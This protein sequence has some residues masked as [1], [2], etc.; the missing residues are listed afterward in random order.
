VSS[1]ALF[2]QRHARE[3]ALAAVC[4]ILFLTFLDNT[5]VS[6]AL[7][8][9][10]SS[11]S[12]SVSGLQWIVD[13]YMLAFAALMLT[14]GTLGDL[15]GRKRVMLG[16]VALF[17][18][19][20]ILA[21]VAPDTGVLIAGRIV[22][23]VGAAGSEPG[24]LSLIRHIYP[25]RE[26]RAVALGVWAAVSGLALALGPV[27]GG[28]IADGL[29][30]RKIFWFGVGLGAVSLAVAAV[31]LTESSDPAGRRLDVPGL[32]TGASAITA[33]TFAVIEGENRGYGTWW[34]VLLFA[35][36]A[37]LVVAFVL[38]E[39]Q[40]ADPV[41]KLEFLRSPTFAAANT[42]AFAVNL[43]VF[44]VFFFTAL[45]LQLISNFSGFQIALAFTSLAVAMIVAGPLAGRWTARVGPREPMVV[46]CV[47]AGAGLLLVDWKLTA[48]TS[49]AALTWPLA[50]AGLGF[51]I[52]LVTMTQAVLTLVPPEQSGMAASTVNTSRELG[53]V[54]GVAV[55]GAVVNAQ[56]TTGLNEKLVKLHI[57]LVYRDVVIK[58][59]TTGGNITSAENSP[60]V[61]GHA[62]LI[63]RVLLAAEG[64]AGHG[65]HLALEIAGGIVLAAAVVAVFAARHR[66]GRVEELR[67]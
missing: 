9:I 22:M 29:G 37:A 16:G 38:V 17:C 42:V 4:A 24:T 30:W 59:V 6:V 34:I 2:R 5:I 47:L 7:A 26:E 64:S 51:G 50:V 40:A 57:P 35:A 48:T 56:L 45:Y 23:G 49:V 60:G 31:T 1:L 8:D 46:G 62:R 3:A 28:V 52:A 41:L 33:A 44:S 20:S 65:V 14:G 43:S 13:G 39:H 32:A 63:A 12:V 10:Q 54:F 21:A 18:A 11:L 66:V 67:S 15:L 53:G 55:L 27:I 36:A 61:K 25:E 58:F 19:G